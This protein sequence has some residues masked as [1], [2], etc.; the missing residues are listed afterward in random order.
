MLLEY[1][2]MRGRNDRDC[3]VSE[4]ER[5]IFDTLKV[6]FDGSWIIQSGRELMKILEEIDIVKNVDEQL[7]FFLWYAFEILTFDATILD[8]WL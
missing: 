5:K 7:Y 2:K 6:I 3:R 8:D 4:D 1:I